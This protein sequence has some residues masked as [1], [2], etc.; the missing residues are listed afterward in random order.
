MNIIKSICVAFSMYSKIPMPRVEW[1]EKNMKYAM[2]FFPLVGAVIGGLMLL[3]RFLCGRFG[4]NTSVYAVVM[5]ALPV[6]VSGGIHTDGFI[7]TVDALSS[8]GDKEKK[9]EI[10][11]DPHTGAFAIIGAVMY[12]LL[13][14][15]FMTEIWDIKATIAVSVGFVL[16]RSLSGLAIGIF[17]CAKNSGLLYTFKSAAHKK[18]IVTVMILYIALCVAMLCFTGVYGLGTICAAVISFLWYRHVAYSKFGGITGD[19]ADS[20]KRDF[21]RENYG[22]DE[23]L[24]ADYDSVL[25]AKA[26]YGFH[27]FI[28]KLMA[29]GKDIVAVIDEI[30]EENHDITIISTEIGYGV[31]PMDKGDREWRETVGRTC[32][33]IAKKADEVVRVVCGVGKRTQ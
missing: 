12:Y 29:D 8:Y 2:C 20:G 3:V 15:G 7:D 26:V 17:K 11:K 1:N 14:F 24:M 32:C 10:L 4:F 31:V 33:Y 5:T 9:L 18:T 30:S 22:I 6:L 13:F 23:I 27:I 16:S 28:K 25:T 19:I 21:V